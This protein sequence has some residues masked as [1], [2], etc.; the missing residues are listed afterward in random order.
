M[1]KL[2]LLLLMM[3]FQANKLTVKALLRFVSIASQQ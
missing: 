1:M 3:M 2:L